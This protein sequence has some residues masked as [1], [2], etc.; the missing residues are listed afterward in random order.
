[1]HRRQRRRLV[2]K[3]PTKQTLDDFCLGSSAAFKRLGR[4]FALP[5]DLQER[6]PPTCGYRHHSEDREVLKRSRIEKHESCS[7][8]FMLGR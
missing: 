7:T 2:V 1:M 5:L 8:A 4:D 6:F 3:F